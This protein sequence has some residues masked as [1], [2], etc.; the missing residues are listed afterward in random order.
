MQAR[1][2]VP[3]GPPP[4]VDAAM[5]LRVAELEATNAQLMRQCRTT[6]VDPGA[7]PPPMPGYASSGRLTGERSTR[8]ETISEEPP[9]PPMWAKELSKKKSIIGD[10]PPNLG[11]R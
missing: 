1:F 10:A 4:G 2:P 3:A 7:F 6:S 5:R 11:L 8:A 9:P